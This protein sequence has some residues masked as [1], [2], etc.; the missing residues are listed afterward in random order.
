MRETWYT[1]ITVKANVGTTRRLEI[2]GTVNNL[3]DR[4]P[5][6]I[7]GGSFQLDYPTNASL[8]DVVGR[9]ITAGVRFKL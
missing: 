4:A 1:D 2:F 5:P 3:F 7:P 6:D 8:Y 9:T